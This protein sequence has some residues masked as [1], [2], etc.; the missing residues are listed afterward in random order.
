MSR[1]CCL[2]LPCCVMGFS[3]V[4]IVVF[5]DHA[6]LLVLNEI[7][8]RTTHQYDW[9]VINGSSNINELVTFLLFVDQ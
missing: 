2:A 7:L 3:A 5:P 6:H 8:N 4:Q 1:D 9:F